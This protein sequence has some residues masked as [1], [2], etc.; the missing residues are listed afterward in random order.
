MRTGR[1]AV[2]ASASDGQP[3]DQLRAAFLMD[4][5]T[6]PGA[7]GP[8]LRVCYSPIALKPIA[9]LIEALQPGDRSGCGRTL[10][11]VQKLQES[12]RSLGPQ[13]F[14][15]IVQWRLSTWRL[16]TFLSDTH[17]TYPKNGRA[18]GIRT[19]DLLNP[20]QAHYQAVLRPDLFLGMPKMPRSEAFATER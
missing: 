4:L 19:H 10:V 1:Y 12:F 16:G 18:G 15:G 14:T 20:I 3:G 2:G 6:R 7:D 17:S 11:L 9:D 8:R 5:E 13:E